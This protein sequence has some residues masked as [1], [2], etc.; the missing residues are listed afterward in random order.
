MVRA[1]FGEMIKSELFKIVIQGCDR[2]VMQPYIEIIFSTAMRLS[3]LRLRCTGGSN[4]AAQ[5]TSFHRTKTSVTRLGYLLDFGQLFKAF[6]N[7]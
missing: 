5:I 2:V 1:R 3:L 6:G 4:C 7:N